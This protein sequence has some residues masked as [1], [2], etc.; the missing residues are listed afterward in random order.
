MGDLVFDTSAVSGFARAGR[1]DQLEAL[2]HGDQ[3]YITAAVLDE[4]RQ[5]V[6][7]HASLGTVLD[8]AWLQEVRA[9]GL[10]ELRAFAEYVTILGTRGR[11]F[12]EA[13]TLA[14]AETHHATAILDD[15]IGRQAAALRGVSAHGTLTLIA[16]AVST[17]VITGDDAAGL[18][19]ALRAVGARL[20]C[21]GAGFIRWA[22]GKG[23]LN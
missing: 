6:P 1:L 14:W 16:G 7:L 10:D 23:L 18:V 5:G 19:N 20:P 9:D 17:G 8:A 13:S 12:G 15:A 21:D 3:R 22:Q 4:I 11:D 2:T